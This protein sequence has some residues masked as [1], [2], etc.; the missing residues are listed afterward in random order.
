MSAQDL[1]E[2]LLRRDRLVLLA[3][4][5]ALTLLAWMYLLLGAG[6]GMSTIAMTTWQFPPPAHAFMPMAW[7]PAYWLIMLAMWWVMMIAM[8]TPAAVPVLLLHAST[9]R[10]AQ[11]RGQMPP[12]SLPTALFL[13]GYLAVWLL[14]SALA[15]LAQWGLE[16]AGLVHQMLM[17][18][19]STALSAGLLIAA[20]LYQLTPLKTACLDHCRSPASWLAANWHR[21]RPGAFRMGV[22][23]GTFCLG[24]CWIL[25]LLL[26]AGG[27]MNLVWIAGL[28]LLVLLEKLAPGGHRIAQATG[29]AALLAGL[30]LLYGL[31]AT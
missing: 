29:V 3:A 9:L 10:H 26:F 11:R 18:S 12:G 13:V 17:W 1:T 31:A 2:R 23:H 25:M 6:T 5:A 30:W 14:F 19:T 16:R 7:E 27:T 22:E 28:S 8:M 20:G 15:T 21:G 24:C 4:A